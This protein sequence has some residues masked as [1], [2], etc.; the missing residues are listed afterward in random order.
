MDVLFAVMPFGEVIAPT[1]EV[2][3]FQAGLARLG[4]SARALAV[5]RDR[6]G[7]E[8]RATPFP[9]RLPCYS[10]RQAGASLGWG[11]FVRLVDRRG[12][13]SDPKP[14]PGQTEEP[15][16]SA[17]GELDNQ[18]LEK[19][20]GGFDPQPEP[21]GRSLIGNPLPDP[22]LDVNIRPRLR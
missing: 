2:S 22:D 9:C 14:E 10:L 7:R 5:I 15:V 4:F 8:P 1:I 13:M 19:V 21:P 3:L 16:A 11:Q 17:D 18:D 6:R 12:F 20:S